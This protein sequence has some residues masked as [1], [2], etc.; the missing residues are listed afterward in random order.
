MQFK[1]RVTSTVTNKIGRTEYLSW[2]VAALL[3]FSFLIALTILFSH[4]EHTTHRIIEVGL[5]VYACF[6]L[7]VLIPK[8]LHD[9]NGSGWWTLLFFLPLIDAAF[10]LVLIFTPGT[11]DANKYGSV[12]RTWPWEKLPSE[13]L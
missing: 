3:G 8:R 10:E 13:T 7:A 6:K 2:N 4:Q 11:R 12:P 5:V 1:G 9:M